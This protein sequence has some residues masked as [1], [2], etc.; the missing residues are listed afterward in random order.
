ME[1]PVFYW[2]TVLQNFHMILIHTL[3]MNLRNT[4]LLGL[5]SESK[6]FQGRVSLSSII[7]HW[8]ATEKW[9][10]RVTEERGPSDTNWGINMEAKKEVQP[11][12]EIQERRVPRLRY[13]YFS[14]SPLD[15]QSFISGS[16]CVCF[17]S[18]SRYY[19]YI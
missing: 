7:A 6:N 1:I 10:Y 12:T 9:N 14:F 8:S 3:V 19:L 2:N 18:L 16:H 15:T 5:N 13:S 17:F 4:A 11:G